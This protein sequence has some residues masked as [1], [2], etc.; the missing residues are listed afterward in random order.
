MAATCLILTVYT[1]LGIE[2]GG[3]LFSLLPPASM[4]DKRW[5]LFARVSSDDQ[6]DNT[7]TEK[8]L[9]DIRQRTDDLS[10]SITDEIERAESGAQMDRESLNR[11]LD[12]G[13]NDEFDVL[14]IWKLDRLT[15]SDPWESVSYLRKLRESDIILY[16]HNHGF[17]D[18]EDRRDFEIMVREV[19][20]SREWYS[21]IKENAEDGQLKHLKQGK[22]PFG[23]PHWGYTT[24]DEKYIRL[25]GRGENVI[26][27]I[28]DIYVETENRAETRR[29]VND[30]H[31]LKDDPLTD[32]QI[33]TILESPLCLGQLGLKGQVVNTKAD[34][35]CVS[36]ETFNRTQEILESRSG[37]S[38]EAEV[39]PESIGRAEKRFGPEFIGNLF[40]KL[41]T[42]C[43]EP[44]CN[45][46]L[47]GTN[48]TRTVRNRVLIE[49]TCGKC[50]FTGPLFD[51]QEI[52]KLDATIPLACPFCVSVDDVSGEQVSSSALEYLYTCNNCQNEFAVDVPPNKYQRAFEHP[53]VAFRWDP[54]R[55]QPSEEVDGVNPEDT[56]FVWGRE[57]MSDGGSDPCSDS[58]M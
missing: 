14:G 39:V 15:R 48:S 45:G 55:D 54:N 18:W 12:M 1:G 35:Q 7:S 23:S 3:I 29:R 44:D 41:S 43:P 46:I 8:Q 51:Q 57:I 42:V 10:G 24:D 2:T 17:F 36:K 53:E 21:R 9:S 5:F 4:E 11:I 37:S 19:L 16:S 31:G 34:L 28:F 33:K 13:E 26:P 38:S 52:N 58:E 22:Y 50:D 56:E 30:E 40:D 25:T 32:T 47:E 6:L 27:E 20:F 49:Y